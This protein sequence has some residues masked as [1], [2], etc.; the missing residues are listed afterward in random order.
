MNTR[1]RQLAKV[2]RVKRFLLA[3]DIPSLCETTDLSYSVVFNAA[4]LVNCPLIDANQSEIF[5]FRIA[6]SLVL[7]SQG[8]D[9]PALVNPRGEDSPAFSAE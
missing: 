9:A 1:E 3:K 2:E 4:E 6:K 7:L 8:R 5:A